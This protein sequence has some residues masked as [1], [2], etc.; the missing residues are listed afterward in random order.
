MVGVFCRGMAHSTVAST[1]LNAFVGANDNRSSKLNEALML[2]L[3]RLL[4][5]STLLFLFLSL[6]LLVSPGAEEELGLPEE[7]DADECSISCFCFP[8]V[9]VI[10]DPPSL[11]ACFSNGRCC[12]QRR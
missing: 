2:L 4:E 7:D 12:L 11:L 6:F 10:I 9:D 5:L 3:L 1:G 8:V